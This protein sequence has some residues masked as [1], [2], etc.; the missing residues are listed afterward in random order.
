LVVRKAAVAG[1]FYPSEE[2]ALDEML[3]K[4]I[5]KADAES[6]GVGSCYAFVAPHAGYIYSGQV[7]AYAYAALGSACKKGEVESIVVLG[8]NHTGYGKPIAVSLEEWQT[9]LGTVRNDKEFANALI[10]SSPGIEAD[11]TAHSYEHSI[12]VQLPFIQK[13]SPGTSVVP[14]CMGDQSYDAS[15]MLADAIS[16]AREVTKRKIAIIASSDFN[17]YESAEIAKKKDMPAIDALKTLDTKTFDRLLHES[18]DTACGYG[19]ITVAALF[20]ARNGAKEGRLL[21][22]GNSGDVTKDYGSVVAYAS[23]AFI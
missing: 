8:P 6:K 2:K 17:H 16:V 11:E 14:V 1:S 20:A 22:Y 21:K 5:G 15:L 18:K 9:P 13:I 23:L 12:E 3:S 7:A 4:F 10:A 19:P